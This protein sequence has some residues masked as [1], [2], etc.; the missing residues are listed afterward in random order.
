MIIRRAT[1]ADAEQMTDLLNEIIAIGGTTANTK[2]YSV[3]QMRKRIAAAPDQS[4]WHVADED[5]TILGYQFIA[6]YPDLPPEAAD[7]STF[8][9]VGLVQ[10]GTGSKLFEATKDAA[11]ALGYAWIN[12]NIRTDN[13]GGIRYYDSRGFRTYHTKTGVDLGEGL[14]VDKTL[15]RFDL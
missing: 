8:T 13:V 15:K 6:P 7:I 5:G 10:K 2:P 9:K 14:I 11:R 4:A 3:D 12:A 1:L